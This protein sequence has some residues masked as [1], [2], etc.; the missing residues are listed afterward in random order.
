[1][2]RLQDVEAIQQQ[3]EKATTKLLEDTTCAA[4][5]GAEAS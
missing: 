2:L 3:E 5:Y 4:V 1:M